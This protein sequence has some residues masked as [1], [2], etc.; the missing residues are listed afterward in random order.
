MIDLDLVTS[1]QKVGEGEDVS[2]DT[3]L[4]ATIH[5]LVD[6]DTLLAPVVTF[7]FHDQTI[8]DTAELKTELNSFELFCIKQKGVEGSGFNVCNH[9]HGNFADSLQELW[10]DGFNYFRWLE[11]DYAANVWRYFYPTDSTLLNIDGNVLPDDFFT[12]QSDS[13]SVYGE[14]STLNLKRSQPGLSG[15][16]VGGSSDTIV[17]FNGNFLAPQNEDTTEIDL[18]YKHLLTLEWAEDPDTI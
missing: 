17:M 13:S 18:Q 6:F 2:F 8:D 14:F 12:L 4:T 10:T 16:K 3:Y 9:R 1:W 5:P 7:A 15:I 11:A